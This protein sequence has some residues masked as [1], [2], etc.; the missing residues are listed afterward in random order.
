MRARW[1]VLMVTGLLTLGVACGDDDGDDSADDSGTDSSEESQLDDF[2]EE[3]QGGESDLD[4]E[5]VLT[6]AAEDVEAYWA[7]ELEPVFGVPYEPVT[8]FTTYT[9]ETDTA[10]L[11]PCFEGLP[12]EEVMG[13]AF[14]CP[15]DH[16]V[17]YDV[18]NPPADEFNRFGVFGPAITIAHEWGHSLQPG[19]GYSEADSVLLETQ[20][21]CFS[22]AWSAHALEEGTELD[23]PEEALELGIASQLLFGDPVGIDPAEEGAHGNGFDR[24]NAF[25]LG[26]DGGPDACAQWSEGNPPPITEIPFLTEEEAGSEGNLPLDETIE[27]VVADLDIYWS[28][29]IE[30]FGGDFEAVDGVEGYDADD[31]DSVP[32]CEETPD[33]P[34]GQVFYCSDENVIAYDEIL[35]EV[36]HED[37]GDFAVAELIARAY[38]SAMQGQLDLSSEGVDASLQADCF[39]GAWAGSVVFDE[40]DSG[41][42]GV[43]LSSGDLDEAI[44]GFLA[45]SEQ[46]AEDFGTLSERTRAYQTGFFSEDGA[47]NCAA[48]TEDA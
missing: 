7:E 16:T 15:L 17:V 20:A 37:L 42:V 36:T 1:L 33:D 40:H 45:Q 44:S 5:E 2:R 9:S 29:V 47:A 19:I 12:Y 24:I 27:R 30:D 6:L 46:G 3:A 14:Y 22:G 23:L 8:A 38:A 31:E 32:D 13:N 21:D 43:E 18:E 48:V 39:S 41:D 35:F 28:G 25:L 34:D 26:F 11:G 10:E 4:L